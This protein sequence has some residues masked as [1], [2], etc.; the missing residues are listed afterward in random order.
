MV[1]HFGFA[2]CETRSST[3]TYVAAAQ[4]ALSQARILG[5]SIGLSIATIVLN[6]KLS[7]GLAGVLDPAQINSLEQSLN[8][9]STLSPANQ[10][11]VAQIYTDAFN[12][13]M[14]ICTYLSTAAVLAAITTYQKN[15]ASVAA[16]REKQ[17]AAAESSNDGTEMSSTAGTVSAHLESDDDKRRLHS[18]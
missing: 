10:G 16:M 8:N 5:G 11:R 17:N 3:N 1:S 6:N 14:R 4:G 18:E 7:N 13:Q 15:P 12:E 9:I 2:S